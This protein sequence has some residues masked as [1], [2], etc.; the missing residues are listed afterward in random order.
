MPKPYDLTTYDGRTVD[1][2]TRAALTAV[3]GRLGYDLTVVQ[4]SYSTGVAASGGTHDGGG[5][6]DLAPFDHERKVR[7]LRRT[8][9]A[10]WYRPA[11]PGVWGAHIHAVLIGNRR[12]SAAARDQVAEYLAGFDGLAGDGRDQGPRDYLDHRF[13]WQTGAGRINRARAALETARA[14][15]A[16]GTRGYKTRKTRRAIAAALRDI[17]RPSPPTP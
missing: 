10:A 2:L 5:T 3:A 7:E 12:L 15:L 8:G 4:G 1:W 11:R 13:T 16:T 17:P 9:F 14:L 6:V